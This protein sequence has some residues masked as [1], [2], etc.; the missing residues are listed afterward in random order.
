MKVSDNEQF[1]LEESAQLYAELYSNSS[2][3]F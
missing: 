1:Q 3:V 2:D